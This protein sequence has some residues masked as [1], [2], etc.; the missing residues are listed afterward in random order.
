MKIRKDEIF[1]FI[2]IFLLI[3]K[4][5][6]QNSSFITI[7]DMSIGCLLFSSYIFLGIKIFLTKLTFKDLRD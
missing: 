6:L 3:I 5:E 2:G 1:Y 4:F 7:S